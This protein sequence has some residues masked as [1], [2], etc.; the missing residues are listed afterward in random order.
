MTKP[1]LLLAS[2][3]E[4]RAADDEY[5]SFLRHGDLEEAQLHR[6]RMEAGPLPQIDLDRYAGVI[7]GGSPFTASKPADTKSAA[8][9]RVEAE[10][11]PLLAEI[12][13]RDLP[14]LGVCYGVD[15]MARA[16]GAVVDGTYAEDTGA[17]TVQ[18]T[19]HG[20]A[21]PLFRDLPAQFRA[22][23]GHT[24]AVTALPPGAALLASSATAP[25][26]ALR[27]GRNVYV[28]QFHPEMDPAALAT[29]IDVYKHH[30]YFRPE[31]AKH[32]VEITRHEDVAPAHQVLAAFT[33][34]YA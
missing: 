34:R 9:R 27:L 20:A 12:R 13:A 7:L 29:R 3:A 21:D 11:A 1:F 10:L 23:V 25:T 26:Q 28:L 24:E 8:Q 2:R 16:A 32:L 15:T 4:D 33:A 19:A 6:V 22:F 17:V 5:A 18:V 31:D 14:F 30:G